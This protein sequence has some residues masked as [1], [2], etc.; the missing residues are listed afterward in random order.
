MKTT[1]IPKTRSNETKAGLGYLLRHLA[2]K[3]IGSIL[4]LPGSP[5]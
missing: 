4:L 5:M 1:N 3:R 2:R